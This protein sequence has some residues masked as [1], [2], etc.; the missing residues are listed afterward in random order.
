MSTDTSWLTL[1]SPD[2]LGEVLTDKAKKTRKPRKPKRMD[3]KTAATFIPLKS[4]QA[5][6]IREPRRVGPQHTIGFHM[7]RIRRAKYTPQDMLGVSPV[8]PQHHS[9]HLE[10]Y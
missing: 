5:P 10:H 4:R 3:G 2:E 7:D 9:L 6:P 8:W 1:I